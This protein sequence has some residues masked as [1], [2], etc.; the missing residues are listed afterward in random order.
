[1]TH[2][3]APG[4]VLAITAGASSGVLDRKA[5]QPGGG[6]DLT[7]E[8]V[9]AGVTVYKGPFTTQTRWSFPDTF[10]Y[11]VSDPAYLAAVDGEVDL[12][13]NFVSNTDTFEVFDDFTRKAFDETNENWILNSGSDDLAV[14]PA[15]VIAEGGTAFLD[16][17]DG[18]GTVAADGSQLA[19]AI[20]VQ[21][22][23]G[24]LF[25]E[26]RV[27]I[28]D[29]S[30]VSVNVGFTDV[31]SLEEPFSIGGS[32]AITSVASNAVCFVCDSGADTVEW[33]ACGVDGDTDATGNGT[34]GVAP[35][36]GVYQT[37][38]VEVD[39]DGE[40][41][42][43]FIDGVSKGRLTASVCGASTNL[44]P[45]LIVCGNGSNAAAAGLTVDWVRWG[46]NR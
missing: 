35:A 26:A 45:T 13:T 36:D 16:A 46:H 15:I 1:M 10:A 41:A 43:F 19:W 37:L 20:P 8:T 3:L 38:R 25:M 9:P 18:D 34:L 23:S 21:A 40:G 7:T 28:E 32:D 31:T 24:G 30:E 11:S 5:N 27:K 42:E 6:S 33:F 2:L 44:Y 22:D 4:K 39:S 14:D 17:G 29:V 12:S